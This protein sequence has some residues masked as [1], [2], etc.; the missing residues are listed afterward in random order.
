MEGTARKKTRKEKPGVSKDDGATQS[1]DRN[2]LDSNIYLTYDILRII[3]QYLKAK[4]LGSAAMVCRSWSEAANNEKCTRGPCCFI[5][6][7][8]TLHSY[9]NRLYNIRIKPSTG[10]FFIPDEASRD[11][12]VFYREDWLP[13][14]C[15]VIMLYS[16]SIIMDNDEMERMNNLFPSMVCAFLPQIP[17]VRI[18]SFEVGSCG[19]QKKANLYQEIISTID[20]HETSISNHETSTCFMLFCNYNG[21]KIAKHWA[22]AV[23]KRKEDKIVSVWGGVVQDIYMR[24]ICKT[25]KKLLHKIDAYCVAVLITGPIQTWSTILDMKCN[26]K[27]QVE[28]KLKLFRDEV[29][30]KKHSIGFMFACK[31]RGTTMYNEPNVESTIFKRLF[32][33]VPLAGCFG[34]GEFGKNTIVDEVNEEKNGKEERKKRKKSKSWYNEFSTVFLIITYG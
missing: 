23:Q 17:N 29:K 7:D 13:D 1:Y 31:A 10:F 26:T 3:F 21:H 19:I 11:T 20:E 6:Y 18:K 34:Y 8:N 28:A 22:S 5:Q 15:E 24:H 33:K 9:F 32:P 27:E 14:H 12:G 4:D 25:K 30:L 16:E 2:T